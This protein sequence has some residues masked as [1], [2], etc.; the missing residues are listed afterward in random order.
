MKR[1]AIKQQPW[2]KDST[3]RR[4]ATLALQKK[5][6]RDL[7]MH[8]RHL[9]LHAEYLYL[10][11]RDE[12]TQLVN[13]VTS[14]ASKRQNRENRVKQRREHFSK[15]LMT[16]EWLVDIPSDINGSG[17]TYGEGW[18]VLPRP[19]GKRCLVVA[20]G[21]KTT[22]RTPSG[23]ILKK[24][25]STL[26]CGSY[27][28]NKST[29]GYCIL[30]CIYQEQDET[31]YVLDVMCWKGYLL[32]NC[33]SEFRQYWMRDKLSEES[34]ASVSSANP[35][36]ILPLP[37]YECDQAGIMTAY[38]TNYRFV[39]SVQDRLGTVSL[40]HSQ[41]SA[42]LSLCHRDGLLFYMKA[43]HYETG[44]SPL[45]LAWKDARTSR[46]FIIS[47]KPSIVLRLERGNEFVTL[48][49]I[50][51]F[52]CDQD[53][54]QQQELSDGDL[55]CFNFERHNVDGNRSPYLANLTF[56]KRCSPQRALPD[57]W[58][59]ILFQQKAQSGGI[60]IERI[61]QASQNSITQIE[62]EA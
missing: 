15:Q 22:A 5:A 33:T 50:V 43:G 26:P 60:T 2:T 1:I 44:L 28:T 12:D 23:C 51:L 46:F 13:N 20:N 42:N 34:T 38:S 36:L 37:Y 24:F 29:E 7:T 10:D 49:C 16:P 17:S 4:Q 57:S 19:E 39:K 59:K 3:A 53:F 54:I 56:V 30:D 55:A 18:Y 25:P 41:I 62:M 58:T 40:I 27:K 52:A 61:L 11:G 48:E 47:S 8:A 14:A 21:G 35:F 32:Y 6:R 31:F 45:A 9:A